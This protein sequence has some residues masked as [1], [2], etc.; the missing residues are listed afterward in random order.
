MNQQEATTSTHRESVVI[1]GELY[2]TVYGAAK[3]LKIGRNSLLNAVKNGE[4]THLDHPTGYLFSEGDLF[5][6]LQKRTVK[7]KR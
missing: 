4:I 3:T 2:Y 6:W 7:S 1:L 5:G